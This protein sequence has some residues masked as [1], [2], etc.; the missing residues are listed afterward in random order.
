MPLCCTAVLRSGIYHSR[1]TADKVRIK[2]YDDLS[3][4]EKRLLQL[5]RSAM[6]S[7]KVVTEIYLITG[8]LG[9]SAQF[10]HQ[11]LIYGQSEEDI[12]DAITC[13]CALTVGGDKPLLSG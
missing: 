11:I 3:F 8:G 2:M 9:S 7:T 6:S 13:I 10:V 12:C 5:V 1:L 4:D